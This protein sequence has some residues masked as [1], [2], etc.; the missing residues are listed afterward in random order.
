M[1]YFTSKAID[2]VCKSPRNYIYGVSAFTRKRKWGFEDFIKHII[3][4]KRKTIRNN[5]DTH[6]KYCTS[7][8]DSY[9]NQSFS[10][11]RVNIMPAVFKQISL[12]YLNN[13]GYFDFKKK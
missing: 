5:I 4:N 10:E 9:R 11:Q 6:L 8:I 1:F 2:S 7:D 3:F 12:N 13:I